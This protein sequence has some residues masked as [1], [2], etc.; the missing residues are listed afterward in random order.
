M[1]TTRPLEC[2]LTLV[3]ISRYKKRLFT[4]GIRKNYSKAQKEI[5]IKEL[6]SG[7]NNEV[8][9]QPPFINSKPL[10]R[11]RII[12][13]LREQ[14]KKDFPREAAELATTSVSRELPPT[15]SMSTTSRYV[16]QAPIM[17][18]LYGSS[19]SK[20][21]DGGGV[22]MAYSEPH[23]GVCV[24]MEEVEQHFWT[25]SGDCIPS[26][27]LGHNDWA[28]ERTGMIESAPEVYQP[29]LQQHGHT[30]FVAMSDP[31]LQ[32]TSLV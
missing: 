13:Y 31:L 17:A 8:I 27:S 12:R 32:E 19:Y 4:W 29:V 24:P 28:G 25:D 18:E 6:A 3:S 20:A 14:R 26:L 30:S 2:L 11:D 16:E 21:T 5:A 10:K 9:S 22:V 1:F 15:F 23:W 7:I